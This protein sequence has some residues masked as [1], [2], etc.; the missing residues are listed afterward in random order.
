MEK[1]QHS[2]LV[3]LKAIQIH[4]TPLLMM[5]M[6]VVSQKVKRTVAMHVY[7]ESIEENNDNVSEES[8]ADE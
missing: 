1:Y 7:E 2:L 3:L 6:K 4:L 8:S 5:M